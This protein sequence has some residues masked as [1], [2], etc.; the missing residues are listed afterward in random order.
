MKKE[1]DKTILFNNISFLLKKR[2]IRIGDIEADVGVS[3]G[4]ISRASKEGNT[5]PGI[6]FIVN[7]SETL[8]INLETFLK[9]DISSLPESALYIISFLNK[10]TK[11]TL[12][13]KLS[14]ER[15]SANEVSSN[16]MVDEMYNCSHPLFQVETIYVPTPT[17][18]PQQ[19]TRPVFVSRSFDTQTGIAGD[20]FELLMQNNVMLYFM[21]IYEVGGE[22][23]AKEIWMCT[24]TREKQF[25][26]STNDIPEISSLIETLYETISEYVK[27]PKVIP[28]IKSAIDAFMADDSESNGPE[29]LDLG[30]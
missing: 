20:C 9:T 27:H 28:S 5:K 21:N 1:F 17:E 3:P 23:S 18:Y 25:L 7:V 16:I 2:G 13:E 8:N 6:D 15:E 10:L 4:Y 11:D 19:E 29:V 30:F 22:S 12:A 26:C 24:N 14:W